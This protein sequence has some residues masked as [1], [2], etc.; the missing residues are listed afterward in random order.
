M[1]IRMIKVG[2]IGSGEVANNHYD[3]VRQCDRAQLVAV[4]DVDADLGR[5]KASDWGVDFR[6]SE[7]LIHS[8]DIDVIFVLT[9]MATHFK[10]AKK[11]LEQGKHVLI[12]KPVSLQI[13]EI[14]QLDQLSEKTGKV[15]MPGHSYLYLPELSRMQKA[16]SEEA[17][18][19]LHYMFMSETYL[20]ADEKVKK[21]NG[22]STEVICHHAYVM[23]ALMGIPRKIHSFG[24][25]FR[26]EQFPSSDE[27]VVVNAEFENGALAQLFLSWAG[28]DETSDPLTWKLKVLGAN[29]GMHFSRRDMVKG[30]QHVQRNQILYDEAFEREVDYL[31]KKCILQKRKPLST[32]KNAAATMQI[33][34]AIHSSIRNERV[35]WIE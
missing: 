10:C 35:E 11:A 12:E 18:G 7:R 30:S 24:T 22:P 6:S 16:I 8:S 20:M 3:A 25:C 33:V 15:C 34:N 14:Q 4:N 13:D 27:Q 21:Y 28:F 23:I 2:F 5:K 17:I 31:I 26:K 19:R 29:G 1:S 9:P 32:M